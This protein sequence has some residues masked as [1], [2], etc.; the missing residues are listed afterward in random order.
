MISMRSVFCVLCCLVLPLIVHAQPS[1]TANETPETRFKAKYHRWV[2]ALYEHPGTLL[3]SDSRAYTSFPEFAE[4]VKLGT[5]ALPAI[6]REIQNQSDM[7]LF[8]G[9]AILQI[10]LWD[11]SDFPAGSL[12]QQ[13]E[14][15]L[16]RLREKQIIPEK[17]R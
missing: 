11:R 3:L 5:P 2:A 15:L 17:R 16:K 4:I 9:E 8:L 1:E 13:N 10:T 7:A 14:E 6:A 12:Q